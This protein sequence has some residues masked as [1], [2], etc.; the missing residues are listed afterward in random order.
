[1]RG[2]KEEWRDTRFCSDCT[3]FFCFWLCLVL[4]PVFAFAFAFVYEKRG[5]MNQELFTKSTN[6]CHVIDIVVVCC[7]PG[8]Y[9]MRMILLLLCVHQDHVSIQCDDIVVLAVLFTSHVTIPPP[10]VLQGGE[11]I[12]SK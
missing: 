4:F 9:P 3:L 10:A 8:I 12:V 5:E 2:I 11:V 7:S 6:L 1:M